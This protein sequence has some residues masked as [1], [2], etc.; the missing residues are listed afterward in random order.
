MPTSGS[1]LPL[2]SRFLK[3]SGSRESIQRFGRHPMCL[4]HEVSELTLCP[5]GQPKKAIG[6]ESQIELWLTHAQRNRFA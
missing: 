2:A 3:R 6:H 4:R 1:F 5:L